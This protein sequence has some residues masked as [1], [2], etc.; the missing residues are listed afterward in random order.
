MIVIGIWN[1]NRNR[2]MIPEAVS[3]R[4]GSGGSAN[5]L[6]FIGQEL[7][8][9]IEQNY[10]VSDFSLLYGMSNSALFAVY[11]LLENPH[12]F[13]AVIASSPMIGHCSAYMDKKATEFV[14]KDHREGLLLYMIYGD[15]DSRRVTEFVPDLQNYLVTNAP[16]GFKSKLEILEGEGHVPASSLS[17]GLQFIF[18]SIT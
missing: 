1:T 13:D 3:H 10:R 12:V 15:E 14:A 16:S 2:D 5:F 9:Y 17:R 18:G 7:M 8:P 11:A 4:P 6:L